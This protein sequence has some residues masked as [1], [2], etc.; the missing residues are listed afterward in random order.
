M[1]G[2]GR[3][4]RHKPEESPGLGEGQGWDTRLGVWTL[5]GFMS[6]HH[7]QGLLGTWR[8]ALLRVALSRS[9][10]S[11][12]SFNNACQLVLQPQMPWFEKC[13]LR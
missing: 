4:E 11:A 12:S 9:A 7:C 2:A 1:C 10:L 5:L 8:A 6:T 13:A 3:Y